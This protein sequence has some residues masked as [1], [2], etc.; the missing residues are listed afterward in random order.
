MYISLLYLYLFVNRK[1]YCHMSKS[2][3]KQAKERM[4]HIRLDEPTHRRLKVFAARTGVTVQSVVEN[5]IKLKLN[6][7]QA[8][9]NQND[10]RRA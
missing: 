8:A 10:E 3:E 6:G 7:D 2:G 5:L 4:I 1:K 9:R